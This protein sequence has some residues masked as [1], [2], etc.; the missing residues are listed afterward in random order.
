MVL[1]MAGALALLIVLG[2][3]LGPTG[4]RAPWAW[5]DS[6]IGLR[7]PRVLLAAIVGGSLALSGVAMQALLQNDLADPY[8]LG[9]AG[10]ASVG[11]V[12]SLALWPT[13]PPGP[14]AALGAAGAVW[15]VRRLA[16]RLYDPLRLL[17]SGIAVSSILGS[18]T[19]LILTL[20]PADRLLRSAT[21]WLFGGFGTPQWSAIALPAALLLGVGAWMF[22]RSERLD[23]LSLGSDVA[24]SLGVD[25]N[26]TRRW[27]LLASVV[28]TAGAVAAA[29]L[30]G[31]V[32][33]LAPHAARLVAG[34]T[35][36]RLLPLA[37]LGGA[38]LVVSA[39]ILARTAFAPREVP[40][41][42]LTATLGGP[43]FLFQLHRAT[44]RADRR[45]A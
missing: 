32:G 19:G 4:V 12:S 5:Q 41:G 20:A 3:S 8:I 1:L 2:M 27:V 26:A 6:I 28:L 25:L 7:V 9:L 15:V 24:T 44:G 43:F 10:G 13:L 17:L 31:F 35:H 39:D 11:A 16:G 42:L 37:L 22:Q 14:A 30:V 29:G 18:A 23:R 36:R 40:V 38:A 33:L 34:A 45:S 21:F